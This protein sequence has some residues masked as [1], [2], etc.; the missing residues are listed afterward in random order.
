MTNFLE[1][2]K[3]IVNRHEPESDEHALPRAAAVL[4]LELAATD[5]GI[6]AQERHVIERAVKER[7]GLA[8]A[9]LRE[10]LD[11]AGRQQRNVHSL[12]E[13]TH[14]LRTGLDSATRSELVEWLWRVAY[15]TGT[16]NI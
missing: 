11:E 6:D 15:A 14:Q 5:A 16:R 10:L 13:F 1:N 3:Q 4:L 2:L 7:F 12:H 9:E 8:S